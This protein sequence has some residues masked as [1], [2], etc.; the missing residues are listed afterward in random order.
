M[1]RFVSNKVVFRY[2]ED[3]EFSLEADKMMGLATKMGTKIFDGLV[4]AISF[5]AVD[6]KTSGVADELGKTTDN[7]LHGKD[8]NDKSK[9]ERQSERK[10]TLASAGVNAVG[11]VMG[12]IPS[13]LDASH[14]H[15][16]YSLAEIA[17]RFNAI[18][19][20]IRLEFNKNLAHR[21]QKMKGL[22]KNGNRPFNTKKIGNIFSKGYYKIVPNIF[23]GDKGGFFAGIFSRGIYLYE[24]HPDEYFLEP[25]ESGKFERGIVN[26]DPV[27]T[28]TTIQVNHKSAIGRDDQVHVDD[29][30]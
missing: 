15:G 16:D 4:K 20:K 30:S 10:K 27:M 22:K 9:D 25:L 24:K 2:S 3:L 13:I 23:Q 6:P 28:N 12:S 26:D 21:Y 17:L 1:Y 7:Y 14:T 18:Q 8:D 5:G 29:K 19:F 11:S